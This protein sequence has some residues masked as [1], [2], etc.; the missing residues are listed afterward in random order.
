MKT[1]CI[2]FT[3]RANCFEFENV[4]EFRKSVPRGK[5]S[6]QIRINTC[7]EKFYGSVTYIWPPSMPNFTAVRSVENDAPHRYSLNANVHIVPRK[8]GV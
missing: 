6:M 7:F 8:N 1:C 3:G 5:L 4:V 2:F